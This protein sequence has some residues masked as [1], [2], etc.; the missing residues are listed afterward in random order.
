MIFRITKL[1]I[2]NEPWLRIFV[3]GYIDQPYAPDSC[4]DDQAQNL[5]EANVTLIET[6]HL[7]EANLTQRKGE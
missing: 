2:A 5:Y 3:T 4:I 6:I 1:E 7:G